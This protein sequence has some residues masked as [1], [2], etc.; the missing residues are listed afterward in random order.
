ME[1]FWGPNSIPKA[2]QNLID[3][4]IDFLTILVRFGGPSCG[5][6]GDIFGNIGEAMWGAPGF[7]VA[8]LYFVEFWRVWGRF[9][10]DFGPS[11][12]DFGSILG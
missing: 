4:W 12:A 1:R 10:T 9:W 7:D 11:G 8:L 2:T 3:F 6:D 5:H